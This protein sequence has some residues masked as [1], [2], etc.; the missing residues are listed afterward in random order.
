LHQKVGEGIEQIYQDRIEE[1]YEELAWH[2][3]Q[4]GDFP[5]AIDYL[6][7][8]G[9]KAKMMHANQE[10]I[11]H[12][13]R[14]LE[15]IQAQ[16]ADKRRLPLEMMIREA[17]GDVLFTT[18]AHHEAEVQLNHALN[19]AS[20]QRDVQHLAAL[21][22]KLA[23]VTHWQVDFDRAIE[24]AESGLA[25]LGDQTHSP[26]A[27]SL[28][29]VI[30][31]SY[32]AKRDL[33]SARRYANQNAQ[34]IR[35]I[36]YFDSIYKIYYSLAFVEMLMGNFQKAIDWL[37]EMEQIC[38]EHNS[39]VGLA[40]CYHGLGDS[41]YGQ[42]DFRQASQWLEK[43]LTYCERIGDAHLLLE[44]HLELAHHLIL[45]DEDPGQIEAHI[46]RGM[47][48]AEQMAG[49]S[50]VASA[51]ESCGILADAYSQK[52]DVERA[53]LYFRRAIEFGPTDSHLSY[54][55]CRLEQLYVQ[56]DNYEKF[57][58]FCRRTK[59]LPA[60]QS[61]TSLRYWHLQSGRPSADYSQL[62]WRDP[63][64]S[65]SLREE[66]RWID[67]QGKSSY[68]FVQQGGLELQT[69]AG[70]DLLPTDPNAPRLL[71]RISDDFAVETTL[72]DIVEE[73]SRTGGLLLWASEEEY[74]S[75][76]RKSYRIGGVGVKE[77]RLDASR[78]TVGRGWLPGC[79]L[80]LRFER[81]GRSVSALCSNDG[82][83]WRSCGETSFLADDPVWVGLYVAC[84]A[85]LP[86]SVV[87]F[88]EFKLFQ[89][90]SG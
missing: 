6:F 38:L 1:F 46:Q 80:Y 56:Q 23:D 4:S 77:V 13:E 90:E 35:Q 83:E 40:R 18:G 21:T 84:P 42:G 19:L 70:H 74:I 60:F 17:L 31:C 86:A 76:G 41:W 63:F 5:K 15:F 62:A 45:L 51:P 39:E 65:P 12:F 73:D 32:W 28:L 82:K 72:V 8:A 68:G 10:A 88:K 3:S 25:A 54:L 78:G 34:I 16:P 87:R 71:R 27:A 43:S 30:T 55:L 81:R 50:K 49:T 14:A 26:E 24:I 58:A 67:S 66:W 29:D 53:L 69:P 52:G 79:Q 64:E 48:I 9:N 11:F 85:N 37:E 59:Q 2:Y 20:K 57:L 75:F 89:R 61:Q 47:E 22:Y 33:Q 44:G 7:K 36:P